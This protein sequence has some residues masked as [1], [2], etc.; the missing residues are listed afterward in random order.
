MSLKT[1]TKEI[2]TQFLFGIL[3]AL[4]VMKITVN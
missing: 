4:F 1:V 3:I 2:Y